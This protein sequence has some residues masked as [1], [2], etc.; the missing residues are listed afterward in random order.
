LTT[1][2][3]QHGRIY[4]SW[5]IWLTYFVLFAIAIPWYWPREDE[6]QWFGMPMWVV[7]AVVTSAAISGFT[8]WLLRRA[9]PEATES[10]P[11]KADP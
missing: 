1:T 4:L 3:H 2:D 11:D 8:A 6:T 5:R 10:K 9:W 7:V